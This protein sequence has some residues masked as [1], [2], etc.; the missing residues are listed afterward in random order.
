MI[1]NE[2]HT[3]R[4]SPYPISM[5]QDG[6][7]NEAVY[8]TQSSNKFVNII[9]TLLLLRWRSNWIYPL[10]LW[11]FVILRRVHVHGGHL[12]GGEAQKE[13]GGDRALEETGTGRLWHFWACLLIGLQLISQAKRYN[14]FNHLQ[15]NG[16][17]TTFRHTPLNPS[18]WCD[19][20]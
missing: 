9:I 1:W 14:D 2:E 17:C 10:L 6:L 4:T 15:K 5:Q 16:E 3:V 13:G 11:L 8:S 19:K 12:R 18:R 7:A 20:R